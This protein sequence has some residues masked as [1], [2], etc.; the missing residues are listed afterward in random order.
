MKEKYGTAYHEAGHAF[1]RYHLGPK[2]GI[3]KLTIDYLARNLINF[4]T[5][6]GSK[7]IQ[8][9]DRLSSCSYNGQ[10]TAFLLIENIKSLI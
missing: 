8:I 4:E 1:A 5:I 7:A 2:N 9:I 6:S 10:E 3:V